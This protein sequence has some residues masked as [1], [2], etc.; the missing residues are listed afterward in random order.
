SV[1]VLH[2]CCHNPTGVDLTL[3]DC[4]K[5]LDVVKAKGHVPILDMAYQGFGQGIQ[6]DA[7][8]VR[9]FAETGLT[10]FAS[11]SFSKSQTLKGERV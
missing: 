1:D 2:A 10:F 4:K 6:E 5:A 8:A 3:A 11:S 9:L 7:L